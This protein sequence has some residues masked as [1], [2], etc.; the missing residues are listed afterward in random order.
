[1]LTLHKRL[2]HLAWGMARTWA[3]H[4]LI[5]NGTLGPNENGPQCTNVPNTFYALQGMAA[6][7]GDA[8]DW[9]GFHDSD[10]EWVGRHD[11]LQLRVGDVA[12]FGRSA[13]TPFGHVDLVLDGS[14]LPYLGLDQ[15]WPW[16]APVSYVRHMRASIAGVIRVR[17]E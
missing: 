10:R 5:S 4:P 1:M 7:P 9:A 3:G 11:N 12:V 6:V 17:A 13:E 16:G 15:D 14:R 8:A 2:Q